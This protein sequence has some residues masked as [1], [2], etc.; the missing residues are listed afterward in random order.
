MLASNDRVCPI[1][2]F[3]HIPFPS[4]A[5]FEKLAYFE[6]ILEGMLGKCV[7]LFAYNGC[8]VLQV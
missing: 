8:D 2:F 5:N 3:L 6:D 1:G 4:P 7:T